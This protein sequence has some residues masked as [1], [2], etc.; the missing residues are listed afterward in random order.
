MNTDN[1]PA[2]YAA[3][4][5]IDYPQKLDRMTT[6]FRILWIIPIAVILG[7][8]SG[9]GETV[10]NTVFINQ[11]GEVIRKT[12]ETVGG[13]VAGLVLATALMILFRRLYPR[14]WFDFSRELTRFEARARALMRAFLQTDTRPLSTSSL[15]TWKLITP[16]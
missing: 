7:L 13:L 11:T 14:W 16:T 3:R 8:I 1:K 6:F 2:G 10:T 5:E 12:Q 15:S 9:A 4:L